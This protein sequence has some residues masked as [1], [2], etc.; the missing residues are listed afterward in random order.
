MLS[1]CSLGRR[2][3]TGASTL[4]TLLSSIK[5][6]RALSHRLLT[7]DS[8]RY[9]HF[10][11]RSICSS[12][13]E[14]DDMARQQEREGA[15]ASAKIQIITDFSLAWETISSQHEWDLLS[16]LSPILILLV[17]PKEWI[18]FLEREWVA[19]RK[20]HKTL[21]T[22]SGFG[23]QN[24][25]PEPRIRN[26]NSE[27]TQNGVQNSNSNYYS[28]KIIT[29]RFNLC[30]LYSRYNL[31][32]FMRSAFLLLCIRQFKP[33]SFGHVSEPSSLNF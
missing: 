15:K 13:S 14:T 7:S 32:E 29:C 21:W 28:K 30:G 19:F 6:S 20:K 17:L 11:N 9:S 24:S 4:C 27:R 2:T 10:F 23:L 22:V 5:I 16:A 8:F 33:S 26:Q 25:E 18:T 12:R 3:V 31:Q 1:S